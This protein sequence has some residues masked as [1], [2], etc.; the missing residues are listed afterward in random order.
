MTERLKGSVTV[1]KVFNLGNYQSAKI[2]FMQEFYLDETTHDSIL[3][4]LKAKVAK[5]APQEGDPLR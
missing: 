4:A 5:Y 1:S 2:Q 3:T